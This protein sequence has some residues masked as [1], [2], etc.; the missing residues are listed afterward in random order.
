MN[1]I[2]LPLMSVIS[3][4]IFDKYLFLIFPCLWKKKSIVPKGNDKQNER[5]IYFE[6]YKKAWK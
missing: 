1:N 6:N 2:Q 3:L 5:E 4:L